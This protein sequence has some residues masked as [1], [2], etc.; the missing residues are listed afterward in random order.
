MMSF[1]TGVEILVSPQDLR[2]KAESLI[3]VI[4]ELK[5]SYESISS[6]VSSTSAYWTGEA[7]DSFR[8]LT[9]YYE[10]DIALAFER[11]ESNPVILSKIAGVWE[12]IEARL[13]EQ[14]QSILTDPFGDSTAINYSHGKGYGGGFS[15]GGG[16]AGGGGGG[17]VF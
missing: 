15:S 1:Y 4:R 17:K 12:E 7:A 2:N 3:S 13:A 14:N 10:E 16:Y 5:C 6:I 9:K 8:E 11:L